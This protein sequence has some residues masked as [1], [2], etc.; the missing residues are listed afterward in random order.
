M[1]QLELIR[2]MIHLYSVYLLVEYFL[3]LSHYWMVLWTSYLILLRW[4]ILLWMVKS[5][6]IYMCTSVHI[7]HR[8]HIDKI[9]AKF[10]FCTELQANK[11]NV[12]QHGLNKLVQWSI[13]YYGSF[14]LSWWI[15]HPCNPFQV[16]VSRGLSEEANLSFFVQHF[17]KAICWTK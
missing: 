7:K 14:R 6:K 15:M 17:K 1:S 3:F 5:K 10:S 4:K 11:A 8:L 16:N 9:L 12:L 2:H 13:S